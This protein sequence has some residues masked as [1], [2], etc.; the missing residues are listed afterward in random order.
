MSDHLLIEITDSL[1]R[2]RDEL[3]RQMDVLESGKLG[4]TN[5]S[6]EAIEITRHR[7]KRVIE[8]MDRLIADYD[9]RL[10]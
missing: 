10:S 1:R 7:L 8:E 4:A 9:P 3:K 2:Q 6:A 5:R